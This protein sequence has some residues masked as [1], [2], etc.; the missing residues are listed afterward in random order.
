MLFYNLEPFVKYRYNL[1][2]ENVKKNTLEKFLFK[3]V[4]L[5]LAFSNTL[6]F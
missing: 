5:E 1:L 2:L 6:T 4:I 3:E